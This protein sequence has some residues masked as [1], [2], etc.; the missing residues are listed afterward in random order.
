MS[1]V[2]QKQN[3]EKQDL[4]E[5]LERQRQV[6]ANEVESEQRAN[7]FLRRSSCEKKPENFLS[8]FSVRKSG[9]ESR[10]PDRRL[11]TSFETSE[12]LQRQ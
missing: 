6:L 4:L 8:T 10:Q 3:E 1:L 9:V 11:S 5:E 7:V 2:E 12:D